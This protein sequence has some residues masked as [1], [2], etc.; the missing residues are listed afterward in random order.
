[1]KIQ[2]IRKTLE[3]SHGEI[4]VLI[5]PRD[6][7]IRFSSKA[8]GKPTGFL[9]GLDVQIV[10][11]FDEITLSVN[12]GMYDQFMTWELDNAW[13]LRNKGDSESW[14]HARELAEELMAHGF[15]DA[16]EKVL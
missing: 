5:T 8:T 11:G 10:D 3:L 6:K 9:Y 15:M 13:N 16:F 1:M 7:A 12:A 2:R 4:D 14:E